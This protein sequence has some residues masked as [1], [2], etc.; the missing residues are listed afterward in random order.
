MSGLVATDPTSNTPIGNDAWWP[1]IDTAKARDALRIDGSVTEPRMRTA[2]II[3]MLTVNDEL[4]TFQATQQA[5]G[6]TGLADVPAPTIDG[7]S[8]NVVLY[9]R[10]VYSTAHADLIEKYRNL[11]TTADGQR[12]AEEQTTTVDDQRRNARWAISDILG[13]GRTTVE[14]I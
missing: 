2:L 7:E 14:L 9:M 11:D 8:R 1:D 5:L 3:A 13:L 12:K 4:A 10:A 6:F